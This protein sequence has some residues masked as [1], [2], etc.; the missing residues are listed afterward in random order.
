M[1]QFFESLES[2]TFLSATAPHHKALTPTQVADQEA[3]AAAQAQLANDRAARL[4]TLAADRANIPATRNADNM[5]IA[6]DLVQ[7]RLDRGDP[8]KE[9]ADQLQTR[10][11]RSK[12]LLDVRTAQQM[13]V[14]DNRSAL[15]TIQSDL[16][17]LSADRIKYLF[18]LAHHVQ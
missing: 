2:R 13:M 6:A 15:A 10:A 5:V 7:Q 8:S 4:Q 12:L 1:P 9:L 17:T 14:A 11:D 3:I 18:D 16:R